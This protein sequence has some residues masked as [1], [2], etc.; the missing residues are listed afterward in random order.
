MKNAHVCLRDTN[1]E[2]ITIFSL[3]IIVITF[4][5]APPNSYDVEKSP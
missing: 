2:K 4:K 5:D 1:E 3:N